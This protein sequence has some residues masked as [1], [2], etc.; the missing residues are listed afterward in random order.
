MTAFLLGAASYPAIHIF[1]SWT[2]YDSVPHAV[3]SVI[4][5]FLIFFPPGRDEIVSHVSHG[6]CVGSR[7]GV[8]RN[9][10]ARHSRYAADRPRLP[11]SVNALQEWP[12]KKE[13]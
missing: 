7:L 8:P 3:L 12:G 5:V 11:H 10:A 6:K 2:R 4:V 1:E 13:R 9:L